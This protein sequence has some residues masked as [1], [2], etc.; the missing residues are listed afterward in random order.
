MH[1]QKRLYPIKYILRRPYLI[2]PSRLEQV[3]NATILGEECRIAKHILFSRHA[4][5]DPKI[6]NPP[7]Y[8]CLNPEKNP[9]LWF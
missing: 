9:P 3:A 6:M 2:M 7:L 8:F 1:F 5:L 4:Q